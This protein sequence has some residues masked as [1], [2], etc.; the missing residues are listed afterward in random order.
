MKLVAM[1]I[2]KGLIQTMQTPPH[3]KSMLLHVR[4]VRTHPPAKDQTCAHRDSKLYRLKR[5]E[6]SSVTTSLKNAA[7]T[8]VPSPQALSRQGPLR[9]GS[10][11]LLSMAYG[12]P[13][14][15]LRRNWARWK[16]DRSREQG[17]LVSR[18]EYTLVAQRTKEEARKGLVARATLGRA[19]PAGEGH[20]RGWS[21]PCINVLSLGAPSRS[22]AVSSWPDGGVLT[23]DTLAT[24][25]TCR[26]LM[27]HMCLLVSI[28]YRHGETSG[29][30]VRS[31]DGGRNTG[32]N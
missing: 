25:T 31:R 14:S 26:V 22:D 6:K 9:D 20:Y 13:S 3:F 32:R 30:R 24:K 2:F 8:Q 23:P 10:R 27:V 17:F 29:R 11:T 15:T 1:Q 19:S 28:C 12:P 21:N 16:G 4:S 18:T 5:Q 7:T